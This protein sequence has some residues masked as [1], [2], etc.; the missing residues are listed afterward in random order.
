MDGETLEWWKQASFEDLPW[1]APSEEPSRLVADMPDLSTGS[2]LEDIRLCVQR[3]EGRGLEVLVLDQT[4][5]EFGLPVARVVVPGL[6]HFWR[7]LGKGRL[8]DV[9]VELGWLERPLEE[10]ELNP[11]SCH[12]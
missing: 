10:H 7:R 4:R 2:V 1:L 5:S 12:V 8:Y 11:L 6:R 9:P 3:A